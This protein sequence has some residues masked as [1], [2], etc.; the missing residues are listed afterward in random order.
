M[1]R[2]LVKLCTV[3]TVLADVLAELCSLTLSGQ[4]KQELL[5]PAQVDP[6]ASSLAVVANLQGVVIR[7]DNRA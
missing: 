1:L 2:G 5:R 3:C 4:A 6:R 7:S